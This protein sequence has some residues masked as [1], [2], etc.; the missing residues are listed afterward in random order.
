[1]PIFEGDINMLKN[2]R[3]EFL[4]KKDADVHFNDVELMKEKWNNEK[5][6]QR[7]KEEEELENMYDPEF[8]EKPD[9]FNV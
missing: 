8:D 9:A 3:V 4:R 5:M 1:M 6:L 2:L 7:R